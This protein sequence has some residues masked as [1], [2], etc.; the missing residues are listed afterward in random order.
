[1]GYAIDTLIVLLSVVLPL[2]IKG[3]SCSSQP[4]GFG[5]QKE[6]D[7]SVIDME[8]GVQQIKIAGIPFLMFCNLF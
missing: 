8:N 7:G 1:M 5:F 4:K 3:S 2:L 6:H